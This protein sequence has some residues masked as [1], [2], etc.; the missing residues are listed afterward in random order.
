MNTIISE[1]LQTQPLSS[2]APPAQR[3]TWALFTLSVLGLFLEL[4]LIRWIGTEVRIFAYLQNT[5]LVVCFLGLGMGCWTC[6][7]PVS[8]RGALFPLLALVAILV[9]VSWFSLGSYISQMLNA[10]GDI[11]LFT[12]TAMSSPLQTASYLGLGLLFAFFLLLLV[13]DI[14][15]PL[16]RLLG[17]MLADDPR[18]IRAYS[19]NIAGSLAGILLFVLVSALQLPPVVWMAI[20]AALA[21]ALAWQLGALT[22]FDVGLASA[23][24]V[25]A[26]LA[27][28]E[29]G[30]AEVAWSPYQK[31]A[32]VPAEGRGG[33]PGE[34]IISVN[35][36]GG[37]QAMID[38]RLGAVEGPDFG[39]SL[40]LA[41]GLNQYEIPAMLHPRPRKMLILG[42]GSGNGLAAAVRCGVPEVVG[43]D[44]DPAILDF[45][46][47]YHPERPFDSP[48][49][50]AIC[51]DARSFLA[52][53]GEK[54]DV[55]SFEFLDSHTMTAMT[56]TRLDHYVYTR[57]SF[58]RARA[59]LAPGG[60]VVLRFGYERPFIVDRMY[61]TL[62]E[63][64]GEAPLFFGVAY[65]GQGVVLAAGD[66][67]AARRQVDADERLAAAFGEW[68]RRDP[69]QVPGTT[70]PA[71]DDW[72]YL[73]LESPHVPLLYFLMG[74]VLVALFARAAR[75]PPVRGFWRE[76]GR[77]HWHFFFLGAAFMLL[78][79]QNI[80]KASVVFGST[81]VVNAVIITAVL[82]LILLA[83]LLAA[84]LPRL[85]LAP[86]YAL[87][88]ASCLALY[89]FV[90][91]SQFASL[92]FATKVAVVGGMTCLPMLFSGV[93]FIRSFAGSS[94]KDAALGAN[95]LGALAGGLLQSV[96]FVTGIQAL[97][98]LVTILFLGAFL[99]RPRG[100]PD[101]SPLSQV[102]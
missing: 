79:T 75:R 48:A 47:R 72:P 35:N 74:G 25:L 51:D 67:A 94:G 13:W 98:L 29:R 65:E 81:W 38:A 5:V 9:P 6:R 36:S 21:L 44:I 99:T 8:I 30:A 71:T 96:T 53:C 92:P 55:I 60:L 54:F 57:E 16:G 2:I 82:C 63:V 4:M 70:P 91:L 14:F 22:R 73:Y 11:L 49:V 59:L 58:E 42:C 20:T 37:Y 100:V 39:K 102:A 45:G 17:R 27:G 85:P 40:S 69:I 76:W 66:V 64:F 86:V 32:L 80:S 15:L 93:V 24:V 50:R 56:N 18:T 101:A 19:V 43:V 68:Q 83:N 78:E 12:S 34:Y 87:L 41:R 84:R 28:W 33:R 89:F 1:A 77:P 31:L 97:L 62:H 95:L 7:E 52:G 26:A 10:T 3:S 46:R 88:C 23:A 90:D 61:H